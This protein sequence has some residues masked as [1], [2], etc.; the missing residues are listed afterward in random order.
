MPFQPRS[1]ASSSDDTASA[2]CETMSAALRYA[3]ILKGF[4]PF[5]SSRSAISSS[6][7][8]TDLLSSGDGQRRRH[9][10]VTCE[11]GRLDA[12]V[13][14]ARAAVGERL[15][16][17]RHV[18]RAA[19]GRTGS[20]RRPRRTPWP[21]VAPAAMARA[22][23]ESIAGGRDARREALA[24]LPFG[25]QAGGGR[26]P[27]AAGERLAH[28]GG[29]VA[30]P[31]EAIEDVLIAVDVPLGDLPVVGAGIARLAGVAEH[32]APFE[33]LRIDIERHARAFRRHAARARQCRRTWPAGS[34]AGPSAP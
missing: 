8:A 34:P 3:R 21:P 12:E 22:I 4:S 7:R 2:A 23:S 25:R 1:A 6:V 11:P 20:R 14:D 29:G 15:A 32:D 5:S 26:V 27:V 16:N 10:R 28:R 13:E 24:V 17:G 30:D 31:L 33:L 19:P 18:A 9:S